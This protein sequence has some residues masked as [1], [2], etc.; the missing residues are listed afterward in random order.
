MEKILEENKNMVEQK[1]SEIQ[2]QI[3]SLKQL[4]SEMDTKTFIASVK[5]EKEIKDLKEDIVK[6]KKE[7]QHSES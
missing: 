1:F 7:K 5:S 4:M 3:E 2:S 6:M